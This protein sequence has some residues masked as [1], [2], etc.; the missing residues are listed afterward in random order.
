MCAVYYT[1][2]DLF[3]IARDDFVGIDA[4]LNGAMWNIRVITTQDTISLE[5]DDRILLIFTP[6][7]SLDTNLIESGVFIRD[8][9]F[10]YIIDDDSK[11]YNVLSMISAIIQVYFLQG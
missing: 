11:C 9:T 1:Y 3:S 10:V 8:T 7:V 2:N 6:N 5:D 4:V